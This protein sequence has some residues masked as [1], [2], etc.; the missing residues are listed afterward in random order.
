M[1]W[2]PGYK[3]GLPLDAMGQVGGGILLPALIA[4]ALNQYAFEHRGRGMGL[5]GGSF[6]LGQFLSPP[7]MTLVGVWAGNFLASVAFVGWICLGV[8]LLLWGGHRL[9]PTQRS[10]VLSS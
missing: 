9:A 3:V 1:A 7:L 5:W 6:F 8:S 4:W 2:A 10:S